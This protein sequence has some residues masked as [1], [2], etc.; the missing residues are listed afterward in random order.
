MAGGDLEVVLDWAA[1]EGWNPGLHDA[2][3]FAAVDPEGL[4]LGL[5]NGERSRRSHVRATTGASGSSASTSCGATV[6]APGS[7]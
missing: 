5:V 4:L 6:A 3:A 7:A 2:A 1:G